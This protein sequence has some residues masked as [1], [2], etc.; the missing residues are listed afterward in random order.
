MAAC[1]GASKISHL[2]YADDSIIFYLATVE[3]YFNLEKILETYE[4][5]SGQQLNRDKTWIFFSRNTSLDIQHEIKNH[6]GAKV[7]QQH[8][9]YLGLP[10]L[11]GKN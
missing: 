9:K 7:I 6:F 11:V 10:S 3:D 4:Q 8:K 5:A 1:R 2:F